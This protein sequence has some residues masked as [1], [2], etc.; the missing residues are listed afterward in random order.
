MTEE[1]CSQVNTLVS[2][3]YE[4]TSEKVKYKIDIFANY[5]QLIIAI[6]L[7]SNC[8]YFYKVDFNKESLVNVDS[9]FKCFNN[10]EEV[11]EHIQTLLNKNKVVI[12]QNDE[13]T[14]Y[15]LFSCFNFDGDEH[16]ITF[17]LTKEDVTACEN[18]EDIYKL[19][20]KISILENVIREKD[21]E[22]KN[23]LE[24]ISDIYQEKIV[25]I[26]NIL[27]SITTNYEYKIEKIKNKS[28]IY[29]GLATENKENSLSNLNEP[30]I[31]AR[32][33]AAVFSK[34][35]LLAVNGQFESD[36]FLSIKEALL[37]IN[38]IYSKTRAKI[39][40]TKLL[41]K[42]SKDGDSCEIFHNKCDRIK[43]T[44]VVVKTS[45]GRRFGGFT[46]ETW[47]G[48]NIF[49]ADKAAF[50]FSLDKLAVYELVNENR[51]IYVEADSGPAFGNGCDFKI[52]D[53]CMHYNDNYSFEM[54]QECSYDY[55]GDEH[56][57][58]EDG[59]RMGFYMIDYEVFEI[60]FEK[61]E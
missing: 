23:K 60:I 22:F 36:I 48:N 10:L 13:N 17:K 39:K 42:A 49:K 51:A 58:S 5:R 35:F 26:S 40:C 34:S 3:S 12:K 29:S 21:N 4:Y 19:Y 24:T 18:D 16:K 59:N 7:N 31:F 55:E 43:N 25:E 1:A 28:K 11:K 44:I 20:N 2:S 46:S 41:Y 32:N 53:D 38:T 57:L 61:A 56:A 15:F 6:R 9:I 47:V 54:S 33:K 50:T 8:N 30:D 52:G 45:G 27:S 37:V 14:L